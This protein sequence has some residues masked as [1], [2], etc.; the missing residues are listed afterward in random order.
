MA[1]KY[2]AFPGM[3]D[4]LPDEIGFW[5]WVEQ[6]ARIYFEASFLKEIR[7][8]I[9]E[10]TELFIRS[11]GQAS[12]IVHKEM[13]TFEDRG[14]RSMTMRPEMTAS[15]ARAVVERG[16][17]KQAKS[18]RCYY[19]GPM[20]R[21]ERPQAGRKRQ[22]HQIGAE[23]INETSG[24]AD[25][26]AIVSLYGFLQFLGLSDMKLVLNDL[27]EPEDRE[28]VRE[29]LVRYFSKHQKGL[30]KDCLWRLEKNVLRVFD[31]KVKECQKIINQAPWNDCL[32]LSENFRQL[33]KELQSRKVSYE[34]NRRLVRGLD[35]YNGVVF[36]VT[37]HGLGAQDAIAGGGRYD[38]LYEAIGGPQTPCTGFS[39]GFERLL[40]ALEAKASKALEKIQIKRIYFA[41]LDEDVETEI[42]ARKLAIEFRTQGIG[43]ETHQ[44]IF[45]LS[46]HLKKAS[47][48]KIRY[49]LI[50]G[51]QEVQNKKVIIKDLD[52]REQK[53]IAFENVAAF[54]KET[55]Q[56]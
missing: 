2:Q 31:C 9:L 6:K 11:I 39:I 1:K 21:A 10:P 25:L 50:L 16:L 36:E 4:I 53:E 47:Q 20:F 49:V 22:F 38:Y 56:L 43:L 13:Y 14:G 48:K 34:V 23:F 18:L 15:V 27:G 8:P 3:S 28:K 30:C 29:E 37:A 12:D 42:Q 33:E 19:L 5:Q 40:M 46:Q 52:A 17:L 26:D 44:N 7:T 24:K 55:F 51:A 32:P 35:Y 45:S 54:C 41:L